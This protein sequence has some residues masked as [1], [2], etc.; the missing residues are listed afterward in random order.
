[1]DRWCR[2]SWTGAHDFFS[3]RSTMQEN[4]KQ[5][6]KQRTTGYAPA[7]IL[8]IFWISKRWYN[9]EISRET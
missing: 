2:S 6:A 1:M 9:N 4:H 5:A 8:N 3:Q 7:H